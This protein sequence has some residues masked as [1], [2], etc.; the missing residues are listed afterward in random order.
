MPE[1]TATALADRVDDLER[2][3]ALLAALMPRGAGSQRRN[4]LEGHPHHLRRLADVTGTPGA[5][6][7]LAWNAS[8]GKFTFEASAPPGA[9]V[10]A[11][12]TGLGSSQTTSGL[13]ARQ[14]LIATGATT[15]RF[16]SLVDADIPA[17]IARDG[18]LHPEVHPHATHSDIGP[19]DHHDESHLIASHPDTSATGAQLNTV[20]DGSEV[21]TLH[22]HPGTFYIPIGSVGAESVTVQV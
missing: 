7:I 6:E 19:D 21:D 22:T 5:S 17:A 12:T 20:T 15:A 1:E 4:I 8:L 10:L 9:H 18:E 13:T 16:R 14:V 2:A 3:Q 11:D